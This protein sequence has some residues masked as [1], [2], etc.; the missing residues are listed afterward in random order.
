MNSLFR[1]FKFIWKTLN[2][3]RRVVMN[4]VFLL[5]VLL[6]IT[7]FSLINS[8]SSQQ[9]SAQVDGALW[10]ALDGYLADNREQGMTWQQ[11]LNELEDKP[12]PRK[13]STFDVVYTIEAAKQD[14]RIKGLVLDLNYFEGADLPA[15]EYIG[16]AIKDFKQQKKP[17]IAFADNYNQSQYLLASFADEIYL[18]PVGDV[19]IHGLSAQNL[20]FKSLL[21]K[22]EITPHIFRVGTYKSAVEPFLRD[23][24]SPEAKTNTQRWL[25]AMWENYLDLVA[26]NRQIDKSKVLPDSAQFLAELKSLK[27]DSTAYVKQRKLVTH[28]A[29]RAEMQQK[30]TALFGKTESNEIKSIDFDDY[31]A[32]L[33]DRFESQNEPKIAVINVEGAIVDG[34]NSEEDVGGDS[35][36]RLLNL[37]K[38]DK[39]VKAVILRVNS[40]GGSAFASEIIRQEI[41]NLQRA[42]KPVVTSMGAMAASG[43]YWIASTTDYIIADKNTITGSIGIFAM[44]P[45]F[46][47]SLKKI[48]VTEDGVSTSPLSEQSA[49][50]P[51]SKT[52]NDI[53]Q[54]EIEHGYDKFLDVVSRGRKLTKQEVDKIA[55]GQVW[56]GQEAL[57]HKLV[58]ELGDF[59]S[60]VKKA[61]DL[62]NQ[63]LGGEQQYAVEWF[64]EEEKGLAALVQSLRKEMRVLFGQSFAL[65]KVLEQY[66]YPL[67]NLNRFNDPKGQYLYCLN[68]AKVN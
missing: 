10:L 5:F 29:T 8:N 3:V 52:V 59:E 51:L 41:D 57:Q 50:S 9:H 20:Y 66:A 26:H 40:P 49:F 13:I 21:E 42:G 14:E 32:L 47:N 64:V 48:G 12:I 43:G 55:Q 7:V 36:S 68:C 35:V 22:L 60:A 31:L 1:F 30:L 61:Q 23:N 37:A 28:F 17:V 44:F 25:G 34:E 54:M 56:L 38:Q 18:N 19:N 4:L 2:F 33:P 45:T 63:K 15:L 53:Y 27:G 58:D 65:P 67:H 62:A 46:E 11:A 24:M 16:N 39:S 6:A